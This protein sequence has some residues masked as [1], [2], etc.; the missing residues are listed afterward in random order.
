[1]NYEKWDAYKGG[2]EVNVHGRSQVI[3]PS[4]EE[5]EFVC[6]KIGQ[7]KFTNGAKNPPDPGE[8]SHA[9]LKGGD[10]EVYSKCHADDML[11][12]KPV[13]QNGLVGSSG[14]NNKVVSQ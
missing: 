13:R 1:M 2:M 10:T 8:A 5:R 12:E 14:P 4:Q 11:V 6:D 7:G 9:E 3:Y